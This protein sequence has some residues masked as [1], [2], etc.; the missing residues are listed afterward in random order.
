MGIIT[1]ITDTFGLEAMKKFIDKY[2]A[3]KADYERKVH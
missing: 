1:I 3:E 2:N